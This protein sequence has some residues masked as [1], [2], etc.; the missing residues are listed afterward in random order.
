MRV[1]V[2]A[3]VTYLY[4]VDING[5]FADSDVIY[6]DSADPVYSDI[7][8]LMN[9]EHLNFEGKILSISDNEDEEKVLYV[10]E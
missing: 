5:N 10:G 6:C 7:C 2:C 8:K 9:K 1:S 3:Q 4:E